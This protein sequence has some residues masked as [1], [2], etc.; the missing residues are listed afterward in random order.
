MLEFFNQEGEK[1]CITNVL[2]PVEMFNLPND[3]YFV[4]RYDMN[5]HFIE[6]HRYIRD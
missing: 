3:V 6:S 4:K 1:V 5:G 2:T